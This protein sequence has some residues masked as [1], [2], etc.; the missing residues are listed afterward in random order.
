MALS[1][2]ETTDP[3]SLEFG[4]RVFEL[5]RDENHIID[6]AVSQ[7]LRETCP[8]EIHRSEDILFCEQPVRNSDL[9]D[10]LSQLVAALQLG[11]PQSFTIQA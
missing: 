2:T 5:K 6:V 11:F 3:A 10:A 8:G 4:L 9:A 1:I 7:R